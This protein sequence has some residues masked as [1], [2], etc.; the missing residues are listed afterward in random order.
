MKT[1]FLLATLLLALPATALA[2]R[3]EERIEA[4]KARVVSAGIPASLLDSKV[5]EGRAK[6]VP[7]ERIAAVVEQRDAALLRAHTVIAQRGRTASEA[8]LAAGADALGSGISE[9]VLRTISETA[10]QERRAV[11]ITA[12]TELVVLGERPEEALQRVTDALA[13]GPDALANLPAQARGAQGR[14][15]P[16]AGTPAAGRGGGP[17]AGVPASGRRPDRGRPPGG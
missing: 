11:A 7:M 6:G 10:P 3:P 5:A 2:Q 9:A 13:A 4:A 14:G 15:G 17:P 8:D 12:L 16:P 1:K